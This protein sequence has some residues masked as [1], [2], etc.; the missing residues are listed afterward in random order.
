MQ[1]ILVDLF[2]KTQCNSDKLGIEKK[3]DDTDKKNLWC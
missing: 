2:L 1:L 3:I